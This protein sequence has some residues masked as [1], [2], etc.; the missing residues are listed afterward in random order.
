MN[1]SRSWAQGSKCN[2]QLRAVDD[3]NNSRS[4]ELRELD[5]VKRAGL[6]ILCMI[7]GCK[8]KAS[9]ALN[10]SGLWIT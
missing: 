3:M 2:E 8:L 7:L 9:N 6:W 5:V 10:K 1:D 4:H